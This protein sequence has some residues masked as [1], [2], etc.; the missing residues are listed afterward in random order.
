M[1]RILCFGDSN[2]YGYIPD[3]SGRYDE[4]SR[5]PMKLQYLL[6]D[7]YQIIEDGV[8]GRTTIFHDRYKEKM[9]GYD[10]IEKI[11]ITYQPIDLLIVM[12]GTNDCKI[13]FRASAKKIAWGLDH[14][15]EKAKSVTSSHLKVLIISPIHLGKNI[16]HD[17]Y[18][19]EYDDLSE[20]TAKEL[21]Q[22]YQRLAIDKGYEF[23]DAS[24]FAEPSPIDRQHLDQF[25]HEL[26]SLAIAKKVE[27][28]SGC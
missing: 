24:T 7:D 2:T 15:I 28:L 23:L 21:A 18:D 14:L 26:L 6:K 5:W 8:C 22:A 25:G 27:E 4:H 19:D 10:D 3:G 11:M 12:L 20:K 13:Q 17:G 1:K 9:C 16:G